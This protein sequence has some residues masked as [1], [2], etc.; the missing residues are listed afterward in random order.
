LTCPFHKIVV[1]S[2]R[3]VGAPELAWEDEG[4]VISAEEFHKLYAYFIAPHSE[5]IAKQLQNLDCEFLNVE[6]GD[7]FFMLNTRDSYRMSHIITR[8]G[9]Y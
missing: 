8:E 3:R 9:S 4:K 1:Q 7:T 5:D 6:P 2:F